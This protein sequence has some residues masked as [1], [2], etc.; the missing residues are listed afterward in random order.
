MLTVTVRQ[1]TG[2]SLTQTM[3]AIR[4]W[5]DIEGIEPVAFQPV[6]MGSRIGFEL[7][8]ASEDDADLF[9]QEFA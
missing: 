9:G 1:P 6:A 5:L 4:T 3:G 7:R 8:F 2:I